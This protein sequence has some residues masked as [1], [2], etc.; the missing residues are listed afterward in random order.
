MTNALRRTAMVVVAAAL[1]LAGGVSAANANDSEPLGGGEK[2]W[3]CN[4]STGIK[5]VIRAPSNGKT[6]HMYWV[7]NPQDT[8]VYV[9][10]YTRYYTTFSTNT[11]ASSGRDYRIFADDWVVEGQSVLAKVNGNTSYC[12]L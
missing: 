4:S 2:P 9:K 3:L 10:G 6:T 12:S 7:F 1:L 11:N 8:K 5:W